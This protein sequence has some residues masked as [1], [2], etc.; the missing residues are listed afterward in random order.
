MSCVAPARTS[1]QIS[2]TA[3]PSIQRHKSL[4]GG[5]ASA[6]RFSGGQA[7][8]VPAALRG[9]VHGGQNPVSGATIQ[10]YAVSTA[11]TAGAATPLISSQVT[12]APDGSFDITGLYSCGSSTDVYLTATG[13]NPGLSGN[14]NNPVLVLMTAPGPCSS[15]T[16]QSYVSITRRLPRRPLTRCNRL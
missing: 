5:C 8:P 6:P 15:L 3:D 2:S 1:T 9:V 7:S 11:S 12:T 4:L 16:A 13:G 10:I 14:V